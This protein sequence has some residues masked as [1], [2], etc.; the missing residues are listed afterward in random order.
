MILKTKRLFLRF[1]LWRLGRR[2]TRLLKE[3][4]RLRESAGMP[5]R[6]MSDIPE[7]CKPM[8]GQGPIPSALANEKES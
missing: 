3:N 4:A 7:M 8:A 6:D 2:L 1:H 5:P